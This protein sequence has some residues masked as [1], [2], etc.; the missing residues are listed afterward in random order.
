[1]ENQLRREFNSI[2]LDL[3]KSQKNKESILGQ[4][5]RLSSWSGDDDVD[6]E[7]R[8]RAKCA[9]NEFYN[10]SYK[11]LNELYQ[12]AAD[13]CRRYYQLKDEY[14]GW[15]M[16]DAGYEGKSASEIAAII[17]S[18]IAAAQ[19]IYDDMEDYHLI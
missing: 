15:M 12:P 18:L 14:E 5:Y 3:Y 1:M 16:K 4:L 2:I 7:I 8:F 17:K 9:F 19:L 11:E 13:M 10:K 6:E